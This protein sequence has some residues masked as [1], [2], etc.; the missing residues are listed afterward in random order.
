MRSLAQFA[1]HRPALAD[2]V[3]SVWRPRSRV[4]WPVDDYRVRPSNPVYQRLIRAEAEYW[5]RA[6][7]AAFFG[8]GGSSSTAN[9]N[10]T[11]DPTRTW[12]DDLALRGPFKRVAALGTDD[13]GSE[14]AWL[15]RNPNSQLD[16]YE[17]SAGVI[18]KI[19]PRVA[20]AP[21]VSFIQA[22]LNFAELP[23]N[24]YDC[25]WTSASLHCLTNLEHVLD[26]VQ[27]ALLPHGIFAVCG[28]VGENR[29][30][31]SD[32]R[33]ARVNALLASVPAAYRRTEEA[34]RPSTVFQLSPFAAVRSA[35]IVSLLHAQ[36]G[37]EVIHEATTGWLFPLSLVIDGPALTRDHPEIMQRL[38][39]AEEEARKDP[40]LRPAMAYMVLRRR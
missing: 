9:A 39:H 8:L 19:R 17:L 29:M 32:A 33:L 28:W 31:Y 11:G 35:E 30:Q 34:Q 7:F 18:E 16:I 1:Q 13:V 40:A 12:V 5:A 23:T 22:D 26:Q 3:I 24:T 27:R 37:F 14:A 38:N 21:G 2:F 15:K 36:A 6:D 20:G 4:T 25:I 10:L